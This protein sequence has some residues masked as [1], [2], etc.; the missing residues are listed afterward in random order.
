MSDKTADGKKLGAYVF[1]IDA[2]LTE[3][4]LWKFLGPAATGDEMARLIVDR[5]RCDEIRSFT[6]QAAPVAWFVVAPSKPGLRVKGH[7]L[8]R[9]KILWMPLMSFAEMADTHQAALDAYIEHSRPAAEAGAS[10]AND[11]DGVLWSM[12]LA[13]GDKAFVEQTDACSTRTPPLPRRRECSDEKRR[14]PRARVT[15]EGRRSGEFR[16]CLAS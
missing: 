5:Y 14:P 10:W 7:G 15:P 3:G 12:C 4:D 8:R 6:I 9:A 13:I 11:E 16:G 2:T 1:A